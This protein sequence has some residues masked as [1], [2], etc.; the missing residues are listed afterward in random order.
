MNDLKSLNNIR[1]LRAKA[2]ELTLETLE[3]IREK[4]I[5]VVQERREEELKI[6][7]ELDERKNKLKKYRD[8]LCKDGIDLSELL[9]TNSSSKKVQD[10]KRASRPAKYQYIDKNGQK[11]TWTGQGRTPAAIKEALKGNKSLNDFL[12]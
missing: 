2:R 8:M 6:Q 7:E 11:K 5:I 10:K 3:E 9:E 1:T 4:F 12:L